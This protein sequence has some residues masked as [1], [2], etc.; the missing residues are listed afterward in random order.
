[1]VDKIQDFEDVLSV[2][3]QAKVRSMCEDT[4]MF[5]PGDTPYFEAGSFVNNLCVISYGDEY[6][7]NTI[8]IDSN[9]DFVDIALNKYLK[10]LDGKI[11]TSNPNDYGTYYY[12]IHRILQ[13][14]SIFD[15]TKHQTWESILSNSASDE[16]AFLAI[17]ALCS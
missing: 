17:T 5:M 10:I 15:N 7:P 8:L 12:S 14:K 1:M 2:E 6:E 11:V 13:N 4:L 9:G 16:T 3:Q